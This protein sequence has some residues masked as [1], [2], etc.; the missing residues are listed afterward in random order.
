MAVAFNLL[1]LISVYDMFDA[2]SCHDSER[3]KLYLAFTV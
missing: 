2:M 3:L 1:Q